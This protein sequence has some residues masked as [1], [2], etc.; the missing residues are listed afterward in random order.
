MPQHYTRQ[1]VIHA[2]ARLTPPQLTR[3]I[4]AEIISPVV[5][6]RGP[7]FRQIDIVRMELLCELTEDFDL[8]EDALAVV[9][10]LIDR[11][12]GV[13]RDMRCI[14]SALEQESEEVR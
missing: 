1:Q 3:F 14:L 2:V 13:R 6:D 11:L 12:H 5:T 4:E 7:V 8:D 9:V 10:S